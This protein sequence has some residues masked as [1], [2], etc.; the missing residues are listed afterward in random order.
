MVSGKT[1][2]HDR[3]DTCLQWSVGRFRGLASRSCRPFTCVDGLIGVL[4]G[5]FS[6]H[7]PWHVCVKLIVAR[8]RV[9]ISERPWA[10]G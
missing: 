2:R 3:L 8:C 6:S 4:E 9:A 5:R 1:L 7:C 10:S